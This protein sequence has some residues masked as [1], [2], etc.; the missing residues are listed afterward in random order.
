MGKRYLIVFATS[1]FLHLLCAQDLVPLPANRVELRLN[2]G[3]S[4]NFGRQ[5]GFLPYSYQGMTSYNRKEY[6]GNTERQKIGLG[7]DVLIFPKALQMGRFSVAFGFD[8]LRLS[9]ET[10]ADSLVISSGT[11]PPMQVGTSSRAVRYNLTAPIQ[12]SLLQIPLLLRCDVVRREKHR[13]FVET[14]IRASTMTSVLLPDGRTDRFP[15]AGN[16][17]FS[18][19]GLGYSYRISTSDESDIWLCVGTQFQVQ[20]GKTQLERRLG[21]IGGQLALAMDIF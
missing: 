21:F 7:F 2:I 12:Q 13:A 11:T 14:G 20:L 16:G 18:A 8:F 15:K 4:Q 1:L 10:F 9:S 19:S 6:F 17:V 5:L 3:L